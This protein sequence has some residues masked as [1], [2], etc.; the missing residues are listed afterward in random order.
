MTREWGQ[1]IRHVAGDL[2]TR[3]LVKANAT[4]INATNYVNAVQIIATATPY[5]EAKVYGYKSGAD[6]E[7]VPIANVKTAYLCG[8]ANTLLGA[9]PVVNA[10]PVALPMY[11][12]LSNLYL[13]VSNAAD[14]VTILYTTE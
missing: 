6:K 2:T 5:V 13:A 3:L 11:G 8:G 10:S 12:D 4:A 9:I 7:S 14:A 1:T